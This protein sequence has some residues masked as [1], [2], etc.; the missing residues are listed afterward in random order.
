LGIIKVVSFDLLLKQFSND[1]SHCAILLN[2]LHPYFLVD[3]LTQI[4]GE[5]AV[6]LRGM[7]NLGDL[8]G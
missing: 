2:S 6:A 1:V 4:D 5:P 7:E 8:G 3:V